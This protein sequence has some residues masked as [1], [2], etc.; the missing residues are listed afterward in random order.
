M[1]I[2]FWALDLKVYGYIDLVIAIRRVE[3]SKGFGLRIKGFRVQG[4]V[5]RAKG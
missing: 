5:F 3:D 1:S 4:I 2:W